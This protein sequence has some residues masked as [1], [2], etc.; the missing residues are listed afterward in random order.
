MGMESPLIT[1]ASFTFLITQQENLLRLSMN[2]SKALNKQWKQ[3]T[4][5]L[6]FKELHT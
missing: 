3:K 6:Q 5:Q 2:I 1:S 4:S